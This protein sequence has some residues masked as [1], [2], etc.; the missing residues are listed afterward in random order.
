MELHPDGSV[1]DYCYVNS[2]YECYLSRGTPIPTPLPISLQERKA[3]IRRRFESA[4]P[5]PIQERKLDEDKYAKLLAEHFGLAVTWL[6][7]NHKSFKTV[8]NGEEVELSIGPEVSF[9]SK[10]NSIIRFNFDTEIKDILLISKEKAQTLFLIADTVFKQIEKTGAIMSSVSYVKIGAQMNSASFQSLFP[11]DHPK[12]KKIFVR[13][14][15]QNIR[16]TTPQNI[17]VKLNMKT[18]VSS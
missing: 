6:A 15:N 1:S 18:G 3:E 5:A 11:Y 14:H 10:A 7:P 9:A 8:Y 4:M 12:S 13:I 17:S 16:V 2:S